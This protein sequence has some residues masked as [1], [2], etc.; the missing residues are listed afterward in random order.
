MR[1]TCPNCAA[2][3]EISAHLVPTD[4][5]HV[6]CTA[7]HTRWF[8]RPFSEPAPVEDEDVILRRLEARPRL[9]SSVAP[10]VVPLVPPGAPAPD[11]DGSEAA[12]PDGKMPEQPEPEPEAQ[13]VADAEEAAETGAEEPVTTEPSQTP[14]TADAAEILEEAE[15]ARDLRPALVPATGAPQIVNL[16]APS[17]RAR[18]DLTVESRATP[19]VLVP[20]SRFGHGLLLA[21]AVVALAAAVYLWRAPI[22]V[23][24]P[25]AAPTLDAYGDLVDDLREAIAGVLS[26]S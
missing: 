5:R 4:G 11:A 3:Y 10:V 14:E 1:L 6:Q 2:E 8:A 18:L 19:M 21:L 17:G 13:A 12:P 26:G 25:A 15:E 9:V 20:S 16:P 23:Q 24:V 7:C 22:A